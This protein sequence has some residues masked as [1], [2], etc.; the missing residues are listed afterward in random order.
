METRAALARTLPS[1]RAFYDIGAAGG[2]FTRF[3]VALMRPG[4]YIV[5]FEPFT[6][7]HR[8]L[9]AIRPLADARGIALEI[10]SEAIGARNGRAFLASAEGRAPQLS[11]HGE[12]T[13]VRSLDSLLMDEVLPDPDVVKIDI[14]G[15]EVAALEGMAT[16]LSR[17]RPALTIECHSMP[18]L[19]TT[20]GILLDHGYG[21]RLSRGGDYLG[22]VMVS[23]CAPPADRLI[24]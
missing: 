21:V 15:A 6:P 20:I 10:R 23:T 4:G 17:A 18:L 1:A 13:V 11:D 16:L 12:Q 24:G 8:E 3:A 14:E 2:F 7:A 9:E 5:A 22:P 19:H